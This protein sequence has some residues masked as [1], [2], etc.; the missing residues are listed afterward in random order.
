MDKVQAII[1]AEEIARHWNARMS[2]GISLI[3]C[4]DCGTDI[5]EKRR[6]ALPGVRTCL[7][8]AVHREN[9]NTEDF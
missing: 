7:G 3:F 1:E 4:E 5:P 9:Q 8:C 2:F 6:I